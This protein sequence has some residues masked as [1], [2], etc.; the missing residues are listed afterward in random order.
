MQQSYSKNKF[1]L[2]TSAKF[3]NKN[4]NNAVKLSS[5]KD[6]RYGT[7]NIFSVLTVAGRCSQVMYHHIYLGSFLSQKASGMAVFTARGTVGKAIGGAVAP[8]ASA[9]PI[10]L[11]TPSAKRENNGRDPHVNLVPVRN[12]VVWGQ[13]SSDPKANYNESA[14]SSQDPLSMIPM[15]PVSKPAP[16]ANSSTAANVSSAA[17]PNANWAEDVD[18]DDDRAVPAPVKLT[19]GRDLMNL[20][21]PGSSDFERDGRV[22]NCS[23]ARHPD[24]SSSLVVQESLRNRRVSIFLLFNGFIS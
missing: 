13:S 1:Q 16:W 11:N 10:P 9:A 24:S 17:G 19:A 6:N 8:T 12:A 5:S 7:G 2:P 3:Q 18:S 20:S 4:L 14:A 21:H 22:V 15:M 23:T